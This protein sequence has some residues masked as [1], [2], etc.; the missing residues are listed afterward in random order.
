M[1]YL[2]LYLYL[3]RI[4]SKNFGLPVM[5]NARSTTPRKTK[6]PRPEDGVTLIEAIIATIM[7]SLAIFT[8]VPTLSQFQLQAATN[9][10][11]A[12]AV[13]ISQQILDLI[14]LV[15]V[16]S[17]PSSGTYSTLPDNSSTT[18]MAYRGQAYTASITYCQNSSL[19]GTKARQII[20]QVSQNGNALYSVET[21]YT[22]FQ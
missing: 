20:I 9:E 13:A 3:I 7:F 19:C 6:L 14:R 10:D 5:L 17:L 21:L 12:N 2:Y 4:L 1:Q 11:R 18:N 8:V 22:K 16:E 15:D